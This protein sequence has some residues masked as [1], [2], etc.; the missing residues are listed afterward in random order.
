MLFFLNSDVK[1][2]EDIY[3]NTLGVYRA[4]WSE[5]FHEQ[6]L[7]NDVQQKCLLSLSLSFYGLF[8]LIERLIGM[9]RM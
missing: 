1:G 4:N 5:E 6:E 9:P 7:D 2:D 3:C 8:M